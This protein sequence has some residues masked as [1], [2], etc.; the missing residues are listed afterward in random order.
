MSAKRAAVSGLPCW[1]LCR[2]LVTQ[3]RYATF[4]TTQ[5]NIH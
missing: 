4:L 1:G 3:S 5:W 2:G